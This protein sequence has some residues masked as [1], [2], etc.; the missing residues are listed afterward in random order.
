MYVFFIDLIKSVSLS[1]AFCMPVHG[2]CGVQGTPHSKENLEKLS[3]QRKLKKNS[4]F[5]SFYVEHSQELA[6]IPLN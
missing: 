3:P 2:E 1:L 4:F 6:Y 5:L